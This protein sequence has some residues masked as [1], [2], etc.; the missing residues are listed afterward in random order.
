MPRGA[1]YDDGKPQSDNA[2]EA[3][4]DKVHG[5]GKTTDEAEVDRAKK[6]APMPDLSEVN[7]RTASGG[8]AL[9]HQDGHGHDELR[10]QG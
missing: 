3:G 2:V 6:T 9:G 5:A 1:D 10:P 4:E 8:A 7:D